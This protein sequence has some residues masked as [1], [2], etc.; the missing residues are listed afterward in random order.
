LAAPPTR[1]SCLDSKRLVSA[2]IST[3]LISPYQ[4]K[5]FVLVTGWCEGCL[6][7]WKK[8]AEQSMNVL[9]VLTPNTFV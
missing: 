1:E 7:A 2:G 9:L 5:L 6:H 4:F 8:P 3:G